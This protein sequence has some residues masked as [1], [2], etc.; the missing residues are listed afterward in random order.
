MR[1]ARPPLGLLVGLL[2]L[3]TCAPEDDLI[4]V[5]GER[6]DLFHEPHLELCAGTVPY[7]D[8]WIEFAADQLDLD[9]DSFVHLRYLWLSEARLEEI[10]PSSVN[11]SAWASGETSH[12]PSALH[13]HE[14]AHTVSAQREIDALPFLAEGLAT[15]LSETWLR[16]DVLDGYLAPRADPRPF[17]T[18]SAQGLDYDMAAGFVGYLLSRHGTERFWRFYDSVGYLSSERRIR[19]RFAAIYDLDLDDAVDDYLLGE[20]PEDARPI[21]LPPSCAGD[22]VP[23][24]DDGTWVYSQALDCA[25]EAV[26]GGIVPDDPAQTGLETA[27]TVDVPEAGRYRFS[28]VSVSNFAVLYRCGGCPW[29][30]ELLL[31]GEVELAAG[32]YALR[33]LANRPQ[34]DTVLLRRIDG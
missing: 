17:L 2:S 33:L 7:L 22:L 26:A 5:E 9:V 3:S 20:C 18:D 6:I 24:E 10:R 11:A 21:P 23:W 1:G 29:L 19:R 4:V 31:P 25:D 12:A 16:D 27:V 13:I 34:I 28:H 15:A 14:V 30:N 8:R 32:R